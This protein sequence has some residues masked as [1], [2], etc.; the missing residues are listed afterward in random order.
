LKAKTEERKRK[1]SHV[2]DVINSV[3]ERGIAESKSFEDLEPER[4]RTPGAFIPTPSAMPTTSTFTQPPAH[5]PGTLVRFLKKL[6]N[7]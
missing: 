4:P 3:I 6:L 1:D 5:M 2:D 7:W